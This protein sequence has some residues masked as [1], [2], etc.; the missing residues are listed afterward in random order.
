MINRH[1]SCFFIE[2][3]LT[4]ESYPLNNNN[5]AAIA[6]SRDFFSNKIHLFNINSFKFRKKNWFVDI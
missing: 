3:K 2:L 4:L 5:T 6:K 1:K